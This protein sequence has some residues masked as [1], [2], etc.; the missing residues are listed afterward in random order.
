MN[1]EVQR[2]SLVENTTAIP[3]NEK[4]ETELRTRQE[5]KDSIEDVGEQ[6]EITSPGACI[7]TPDFQWSVTSQRQSPIGESQHDNG[8]SF[9]VISLEETRTN[10]DADQSQNENNW[11]TEVAPPSS[12]DNLTSCSLSSSWGICPSS[13]DDSF[14]AQSFEEMKEHLSEIESN[15]DAGGKLQSL[16]E[17]TFCCGSRESDEGN[18]TLSMVAQKGSSDEG[19]DAAEEAACLRVRSRSFSLPGSNEMPVINAP[20]S[21]LSRSASVPCKLSLADSSNQCKED[22]HTPN[23]PRKIYGSQFYSRSFCSSSDSFKSMSSE[24]DILD[25]YIEQGE[26]GPGAWQ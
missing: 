12:D 15:G 3:A 19:S 26:E 20:H 18:L 25:S 17:M 21:E 4:S 9:L 16:K 1:D 6:I 11:S 23:S 5:S 2:Q 8:E 24:E 13:Q 10:L 22:F 7:D 14:R